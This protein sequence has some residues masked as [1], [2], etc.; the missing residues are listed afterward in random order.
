MNKSKC[1][2]VFKILITCFLLGVTCGVIGALFSKGVSL[3]TNLRQSHRFLLY[4]LPL[5]GVITVALYKLLKVDNVG[6][7]QVIKSTEGITELSPKL[8]PAVFIA[9]C[10]SHLCGASVGREGASL[11]L[12]GSTAVLFAK[13][14]KFN[15]K[16]ESLLI[17]CGMAGVFA[18]VFGTPLTAAIFALEIVFVGHIWYKAIIPALITALTSFFTAS[19]LGAHSERFNLNVV[20]NFNFN[21]TWKFLVLTL[22]AILAA[23]GF[24]FA[25][26]YSERFFA[27]VLKNQYL[28]IITGSAIIILL[29]FLFK[30]TDYNGAGMHVIENI[31]ELGTFAPWAFLIKILFTCV[32]VAVGF[33][34]GEIVP[35]LFIGATLGALLGSLLGLPI[36]F[37]GAVAMIVLFASV[38]NCPIA[39]VLLSL[40]LFGGAGIIYFVIAVAL[41]YFLSGKISLYSAQ[42]IGGIKNKL[43]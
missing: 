4:L 19:L 20:P 31:F 37:A 28:R 7:N 25:L 6:T 14:L 34:G 27:K 10:L 21:V 29:T 26:H 35:T 3:A 15:K 24:C 2:L 39:S 16:E 11:Q 23:V 32:A 36:A 33:K 5:A 30:T 18:S 42:K 9:S 40:E 43:W 1:F 12:G 22:L 41:S 8:A 13:G 38:T 17:Y